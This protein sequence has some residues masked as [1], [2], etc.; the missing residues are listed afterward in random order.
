VIRSLIRRRAEQ[1]RTDET[2]AQGITDQ[3]VTA[4][5]RWLR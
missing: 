2:W 1:R 3:L 4:H 5:E